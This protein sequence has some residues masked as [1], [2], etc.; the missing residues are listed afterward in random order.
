VY[1]RGEDPIGKRIKGQDRRGHDDDWVTVVGVVRDIRTH[2]LERAATPHVYEWY[3]QADNPTPD[4][5]VR[6]TGNP[7]AIASQ[8]RSVVRAEAPTAILSSV[9]T[10]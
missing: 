8:L 1:W 5:A 4:I 6:A 9:T 2:G 10:V 7:D 3:R